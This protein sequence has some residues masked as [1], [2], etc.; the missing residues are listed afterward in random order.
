[1]N[2][3]EY[4]EKREASKLKKGLKDVKK[5]EVDLK[6]QYKKAMDSISKEVAFFVSK[7]ATENNLSY[8]EAS[9]LLNSKE[10]KDFRYDVR[11]YVRLIE[12]TFDKE[13]A[14]KLLLELNTLSMRSRISR[15]EEMYYQCDKLLNEL[16]KTTEDSL[17]M[18][19]SNTV[20]DT[21]YKSMFDIHKLAGVATTF[22]KIDDKL[23]KNILSYPWSGK[24]YSQRIW[25][26]RNKL[27]EVVREEIT[28]M[29][30]Q[31]KDTRQVAKAISNRLDA[32]Y[33]NCV[34]LVNT[35]HSYIMNKASTKA[36]EETNIDKYEILATL[37]K[38][39]SPICQSLD[40]KVFDLKDGVVGKTLPPF[41]PNCRTTTIP[42]LEN[43]KVTTR[44][45]RDNKGK[46]IEIPSN[47]KYNEWKKMFNID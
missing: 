40:G 28:Q 36:Y 18:L 29:V 30:I 22:S 12:N 20:T 41:H 8:D 33:S 37:D 45:A 10:M 23:V 25:S 2:N 3:R 15:L 39:T 1:M 27:R 43:D 38:R 9:K 34:R 19:F 46:A 6:K 4:W 5:V 26:N 31:G 17:Q 13:I 14:E 32:H 21:Y 35:E 24:D 16:T 7:Y 42:Y 44:F 11:T 47:I